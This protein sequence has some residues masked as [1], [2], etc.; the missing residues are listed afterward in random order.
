MSEH[1]NLKK[2]ERQGYSQQRERSKA[3]AAEPAQQSPIF[4][5]YVLE[6]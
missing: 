6:M 4:S 3:S 1:N 5:L 2:L